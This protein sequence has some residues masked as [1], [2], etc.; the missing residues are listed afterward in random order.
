MTDMQKQ[1]AIKHKILKLAENENRIRAVLLNGS[2]ANP[3]ITPDK[4]QDHDITFIVQDFDAFCN[5][6]DWFDVLGRP[7]LQQFPDEMTLGRDENEDKVSYTFLTIF[8]DGSRIDITL[9]P[10]EKM[11]AHFKRD[12]LTIIWM[13]KDDIFPK[14]IAPS[15]SDY[16][17]ARPTQREFSEVCNEFWWTITNVAKGLKR[18]EILFA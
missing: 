9:F 16:H 13:D 18:R 4:Y 2:R 1:E 8:E 5:N 17:T 12:S 3:N 14:D 15:D 11:D 10:I 6:K 7:F